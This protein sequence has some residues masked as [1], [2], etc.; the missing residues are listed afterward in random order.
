MSKIS[1][2]PGTMLFPLPPVMVTC[3]TMEKPNVL[4]IAWTGIVNSEPPMTY[5]SVRPSRYSYGLIKANQE[6]VINIT[7]LELAKACDFCGVRSGKNTDKFK[8]MGLE[9]EPC[10]KVKA[11]MLKKSPVCLECR[12]IASRPLGTH[13]MFMAEI[14]NVNIDDKYLEEDNR[15]ALEKAGL[16]VFAHGR[17]YTMGRDLGGFGFSVDKTKENKTKPRKSKF[18]ELLKI[19]NKIKEGTA[20]IKAGASRHKHKPK[21]QGNPKT[22]FKPI[23]NRRGKNDN[24]TAGN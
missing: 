7:T 10:S 19:E 20:K 5:I 4:T 9:I 14:V 13:E 12:V 22:K 24:S 11:P 23:K 8:E 2:K 17:Y 18:M 3:G 6:F 15:L 16:L 21:K 1:W